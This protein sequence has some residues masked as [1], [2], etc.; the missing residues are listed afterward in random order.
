MWL[1]SQQRQDEEGFEV[2]IHFLCCVTNY[3]DFISLRQQP[4][5]ISQF[6]WVRRGQKPNLSANPSFIGGCMLTRLI[7]LLYK[8]EV[9]T[10]VN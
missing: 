3:H 5:I 7:R 1:V 9:K 6:L 2:C 10:K 4:L 8:S